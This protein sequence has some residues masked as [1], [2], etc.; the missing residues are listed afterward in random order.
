MKWYNMW[1]AQ[2]LGGTQ[3]TL[4]GKRDLH[5]S[6]TKGDKR[7]KL[8]PPMAQVTTQMAP[9]IPDFLVASCSV[10]HWV[11]VPGLLCRWTGV[12]ILTTSLLKLMPGFWTTNFGRHIH[13]SH[14]DGD[15][16]DSCPWQHTRCTMGSVSCVT[17]AILLTLTPTMSVGH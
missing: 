12:Q 10:L 13:M 4:V 16:D 9:V 15:P 6:P 7:H 5:F 2:C 17:C 1:D 14:V 3:A 11:Q 8:P